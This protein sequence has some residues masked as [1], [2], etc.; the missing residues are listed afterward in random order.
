MWQN[1]LKSAK[2]YIGSPP[3]T[4]TP[5]PA[6]W[7]FPSLHQYIQLSLHYPPLPSKPPSKVE[8]KGILKAIGSVHGEHQFLFHSNV[9]QTGF[10]AILVFKTVWITD[11]QTIIHPFPEPRTSTLTYLLL[12]VTVTII[13]LSHF[14]A[15]PP[16][17]PVKTFFV[18]DEKNLFAD[19]K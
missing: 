17:L 13:F 2:T 6:L 18:R 10:Y 5:T 16:L 8:G 7:L 19:S 14:I 9:V 3:P 12:V 15:P 1:K 4:P 11:S